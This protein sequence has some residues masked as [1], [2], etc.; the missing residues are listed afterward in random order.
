[1]STS[2]S[3]A[4]CFR[5]IQDVHNYINAFNNDEFDTYIQYYHDDIYVSEIVTAYRTIANAFTKSLHILKMNIKS[6][7]GPKNI[8]GYLEWVQ[9]LHSRYVEKLVPKKL[10]FDRDGKYVVGEFHTEFIARTELFQSDNFMGKWGFIDEEKG[11]V[12]KMIVFYHLDA[13]GKIIQLEAES[14]LLRTAV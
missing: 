2:G 4:R 11:P 5:T 10:I 8:Q 14:T 3:D 9:P 12:I 1:M 13:T 6:L 7:P